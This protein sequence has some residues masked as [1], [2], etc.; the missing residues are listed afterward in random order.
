VERGVAQVVECTCLASVRPEFKPHNANNNNSKT[1]NNLKVPS[2]ILTGTVFSF[3]RGL[4]VHWHI[5]KMLRCAK[6]NP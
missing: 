4:S 3:V 1:P 5:G 2:A 6:V